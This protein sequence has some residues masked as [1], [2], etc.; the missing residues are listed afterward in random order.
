MQSD[1]QH[2]SLTKLWTQRSEF[3]EAEVAHIWI[4]R[5]EYHKGGTVLQK[6]TLGLLGPVVKRKDVYI[7]RLSEDEKISYR[8]KN[9]YWKAYDE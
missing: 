6:S 1:A 3:K 5:L 7:V 2:N 4:S 9:N 8:G